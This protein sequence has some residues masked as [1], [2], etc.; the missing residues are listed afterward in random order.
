MFFRIGEKST[1]ISQTATKTRAPVDKV[2]DKND[3]KIKT[4]TIAAKVER[5]HSQLERRNSRTGADS[6]TTG[7]ER[8]NSRAGVDSTTIGLERKNSRVGADS[9]KTDTTS[10]YRSERRS[11]RDIIGGYGRS[12]V[13]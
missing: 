9:S 2:D 5:R 1:E 12:S 10:S 13:S 7:L 6:T 11:S 3:R 8:R 4:S